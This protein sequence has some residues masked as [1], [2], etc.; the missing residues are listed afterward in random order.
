[1]RRLVLPV[2]TSAVTVILL[3]G[4]MYMAAEAREAV[5]K[6]QELER[7]RLDTAKPAITDLGIW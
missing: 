2:K 6:R 1:M 7:A 4:A 5:V 3:A